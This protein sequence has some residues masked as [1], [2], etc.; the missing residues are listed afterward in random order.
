MT[1]AL[2][3]AERRRTILDEL[4]EYG[5]VSVKDLSE[6]LQVSAVTIRQ[7]LR[8]LEEERLL[9][10]THG[11]AVLPQRRAVTPELTFDVRL[12][13]QHYSKDAIAREAARRIQPNTT[14]ALD[15]STTAYSI[16]PYIKQIERLI[17]VTYGLMI[18]QALL[19]C[20]QIQV[21]M[22]GGT[23]RRDSIAL[24]SNPQTLPDIHI[25]NGFFSAHGITI[26]TG[27]T[28]SSLEEATMKRALMARCV[29]SYYLIDEPKWGKVG[30]FSLASPK[31]ING[32]ITT[33]DA[34][35]EAVEYFRRKGV[36]I[37]RVAVS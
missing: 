3:M 14:I 5:R 34:P 1:E 11:G 23:L 32:I 15:S 12:R 28:E 21:I 25:N 16:L 22:P 36:E 24:V 10:R 8:A 33:R 27:P 7:D 31:E 29:S 13:S 37:T 2:F 4:S 20:P 35:R 18:A 6:K 30:P 9:E 26:E 17:V 19:D